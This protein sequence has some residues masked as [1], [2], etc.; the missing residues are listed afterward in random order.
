MNLLHRIH[1]RLGELERTIPNI[2]AASSDAKHRRA[3][4]AANPAFARGER[5]EADHLDEIRR[6]AKHDLDKA[7]R[8]GLAHAADVM[9][10]L[11]D[12]HRAAAPTPDALAGREAGWNGRYAPL[13]DRGW[14]VDRLVRAAIRD[15]DAVGLHAIRDR[16]PMLARRG[17]PPE[18]ADDPKVEESIAA[19]VADLDREAEKAG[20]VDAETV[21]ARQ[22]ARRLTHLLERS[23]ALVKLARAEI[24]EGPQNELIHLR[25]VAGLAELVGNGTE[26]RNLRLEQMQR[27]MSDRPAP[28]ALDPSV[29][30]STT[31]AAG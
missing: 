29:G 19:A 20:L 28:D 31:V 24:A 15:R 5:S 3:R 16:I 11:A 7:E 9:D 21:E 14:P 18:A 17:L 26:R 10:D 12:W 2:L 8:A 13:A 30:Q 6:V 22:A 27:S 25:L 23:E 1:S 4:Y